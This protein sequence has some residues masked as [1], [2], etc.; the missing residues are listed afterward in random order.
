[1]QKTFLC[2]WFII[3]LNFNK[4]GQCSIDVVGDMNLL[5]TLIADTIMRSYKTLRYGTFAS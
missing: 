3:M 2:Y 1:M 4:H 5:V